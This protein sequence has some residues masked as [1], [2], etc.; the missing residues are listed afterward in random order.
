MTGSRKRTTGVDIMQVMLDSFRH[1][2]ESLVETREAFVSGRILPSQS[3][4][5]SV[6]DWIGK[7]DRWI[8]E[9]DQAIAKVEQ[10]PRE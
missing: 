6:D 3:A 1:A 10:A 5:E 9:W 4:H 8:A 7:Y 2:R